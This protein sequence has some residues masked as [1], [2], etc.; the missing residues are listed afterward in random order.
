MDLALVHNSSSDD[1]YEGQLLCA[2]Q[3]LSSQLVQQ[4]S[5]D[6]D[7]IR[8][9][10]ELR[11]DFISDRRIIEFANL[12]RIPKL[13]LK[14]YWAKLLADERNN[15]R[16][17]IERRIAPTRWFN[18]EWPRISAEFCARSIAAIPC[19][20][21]P[22]EGLA[23]PVGKNQ[24]SEALIAL[25][26]KFEG[27]DS[28]PAQK[29]SRATSGK[30]VTA[31]YLSPRV[32]IVGDMHKNVF[33]NKEQYVPLTKRNII[34]INDLY[35]EDDVRFK[36]AQRQSDCYLNLFLFPRWLRSAVRQ[37]C[38]DKVAHGELSPE[39][40]RAYFGRLGKFR[41]FMHEKFADPS[42]A[43]I[44]DVLI[45]DE[46]VAWGNLRGYKGKNW[47]TDALAM[48]KTASKCWPGEW[49]ALSVSGRAAAKI[50]N[51]HY[52]AGLGRMGYNKEGAGRTY[53]QRV[54]DDLA[55][56]VQQ[57]PEPIAD[58]FKIMLATG[59]RSED[60]HAIT[61]DCLQ[62]DPS[63]PN[64]MLLTFWQNKVRKWNIK[65]L[66]KTDESHAHLISTIEARRK[67]I[68]LEHGKPT[69]YLFPF[70]T[71]SKESWVASHWT[72]AVIKILC[73]ENDIQ[74]EDG[75]P[76]NFSWH[77]LRHFKGTSLAK[78]GHDILTIMMELGHT[79]P[80][81]ATVYINNRL[82]LKKMALM[83]KGSGQFFTIQ[84][85]VDR[86]VGELLVRKDQL[87]A[88]RVCGGAC[89]LPAQIGDW[90]EH[91]N[92]CYTCKYYRADAADLDY[93]KAEKSA[94][95]TLIDVQQIE[96]TELRVAGKERMAEITDK[97]LSKNKQI[98]VSLNNIVTAIQD[99]GQFQGAD[100]KLRKVDLESVK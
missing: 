82:E 8:S 31:S 58:I 17:I 89:A 2:L 92:A 30:I 13:E 64:F 53:S 93:F 81:M 9:V 26:S 7:L 75:G 10:R 14:V 56:I 38:L 40:L 49:P 60:G 79:S 39:T 76:L 66:L 23:G 85:D 83:E 69:K 35:S 90:C 98:C 78:G 1:T 80:D 59:M 51:V 22:D 15:S 52:K 97:R 3:S 67:K 96:V 34:F 42:P 37:H 63:D 6:R 94:F 100:Q 44:T 5:W 62:D 18:L 12:P 47:F 19:P 24:H 29:A 41:D 54:V 43:L 55:R 32:T 25:F 28:R 88:T 27:N 20:Q 99:S 11:N 4:D 77:P 86:S 68:V 95:A 36:D 48:L 45:E 33:I 84:G 16:S 50:E 21:F 74:G 46:Y 91:A 70:F 73:V 57:A 87:S 61:F 72:R 71:G 65:P